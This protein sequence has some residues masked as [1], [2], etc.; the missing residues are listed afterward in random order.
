MTS[1]TPEEG[2]GKVHVQRERVQQLQT[3]SAVYSSRRSPTGAPRTPRRVEERFAPLVRDDAIGRLAPRARGS[4]ALELQPTGLTLAD[5]HL[6]GGP[7]LPV[8]T[9]NHNGVAAPARKVSVE[10]IHA[11]PDQKA[12]AQAH[13]PR[14]R[15]AGCIDDASHLICRR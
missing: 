6:P 11:G 5:R 4:R 13:A 8:Q 1:S 2:A 9:G 15:L 10:M 12:A 14:I 3:S 7:C